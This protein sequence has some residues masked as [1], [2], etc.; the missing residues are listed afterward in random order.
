MTYLRH[1]NF[2]NTTKYHFTEKKLG[3]YYPNEHT[4]FLNDARYSFVPDVNNSA[5]GLFKCKAYSADPYKIT[6]SGDTLVMTEITNS[7]YGINVN[8]YLKE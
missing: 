4:S 3:I 5:N 8:S 1:I 7:V 6:W 2:Y